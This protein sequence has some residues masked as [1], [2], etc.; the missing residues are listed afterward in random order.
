M[1][2]GLY[3]LT[4]GGEADR[5]G[6]RPPKLKRKPHPFRTAQEAELAYE[7]GLVELHDWA[8]YR[9]AGHEH[10]LTT[11]GRIIFNDKVERALS[12]ALGDEYDAERF[13]FVNHTLKKKG[14]NEMV[15]DLVEAYGAAAVAQVLDAFKD[16]GFH[17]ASQAGITISKNDIVSP[18][19]KEEILGRYEQQAAGDPGPVRGGLHHRRGAQGLGHRALGQGHG[20][21]RPGDGGQPPRAQPDLHDGQLRGPWIVQADPPAG[22]DARPDGQPEGR[23]HRAPDQGQ[24]HGGPVGA[25]VLHL[26]PRR[27]QGPRRHGAEDGRLRLPHPATRRRRPGRD[28]SCRGLQDEGIRRDAPPRRRREAEPEPDRARGGEEVRHQARPGAAQARPGDRPAR[29]S[30]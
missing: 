15:S 10:F 1:V 3:Y 6:R 12:T 13:E 9:R 28:R 17:Y 24:L 30:S 19:N 2:L 23:D 4:Y 21:G 27:P 5:R 25:R 22:R 11:V 16:L 14:V 26:H 20:R 7:N 18:P 8:E 29:S